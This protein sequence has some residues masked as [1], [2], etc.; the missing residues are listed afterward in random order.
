MLCR[1]QPLQ[2]FVRAIAIAFMSLT[3][4]VLFCLVLKL[5]KTNRQNPV[6][7]FTGQGPN[8]II[9]G[10]VVLSI[11]L[12]TCGV[13]HVGA[14]QR[15]LLYL[16]PFIIWHC[17]EIV[18]CLSGVFYCGYLVFGRGDPATWTVSVAVIAAICVSIID[19]WLVY[20]V[21]AFYQE[22]KK[23]AV[24]NQES[25]PVDVDLYSKG[26]S[27][28]S[29]RPN[30]FDER[31]PMTGY[32]EHGYQPVNTRDGHPPMQPPGD[33]RQ[34]PMMNKGYDDIYSNRQSYQHQHTPPN[35]NNQR[36][37]FNLQSNQYL[38]SNHPSNEMPFTQQQPAIQNPS[39]MG[40]DRP[41]RSVFPSTQFNYASFD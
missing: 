34:N 10:I 38:P 35:K 11:K 9:G 26:Y 30:R 41:N 27:D 39:H 21:I 28:S 25:F 24:Q 18:G 32:G 37:S 29:G 36:V 1:S 23:E 17:L 40:Y 5:A 12:V 19:V 33:F 13:L 14:E 3:G 16:Y 7:N 6:L 15:K 2:G 20:T 8:D 4:V 31:G 22:I